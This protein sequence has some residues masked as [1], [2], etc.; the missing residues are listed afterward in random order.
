MPIVTVGKK[1]QSKD[2]HFWGRPLGLVLLVAYEGI[3]GVLDALFG[4]AAIFVAKGVWHIAPMAALRTLIEREALE[5][6]QDIFFHWLGSHLPRIS[7]DATLTLGWVVLIFG[8]LKI[9]ITAGLWYRAEATRNASVAIFGFF[10]IYGFYLLFQK[11]SWWKVGAVGIDLFVLYYF[12][13][14]LPRHLHKD[15]A[16]G[17]RD[18]SLD[19]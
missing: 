12:W 9:L 11:F 15:V 17:R 18:I 5:D 4:L 14:V 19:T 1:T 2:V 3:F 6:P 7:T 16:A 8:L 13:G 10:A